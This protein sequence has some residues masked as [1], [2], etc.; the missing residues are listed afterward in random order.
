MGWSWG[1]GTI[2]KIRVSEMEGADTRS[3]HFDSVGTHQVTTQSIAYGT[4]AATCE[5][6][7][8]AVSSS[9]AGCIKILGMKHR[10]GVKQ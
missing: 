5:C 10:K 7:L 8:T 2:T 1:A 4:V 3:V 9:D 6:G